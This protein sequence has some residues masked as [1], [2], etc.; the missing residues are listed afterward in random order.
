M[1]SK[2]LY[3]NFDMLQLCES[4]V[5]NEGLVNGTQTLVITDYDTLQNN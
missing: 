5:A 4:M 1:K 2:G 3:P